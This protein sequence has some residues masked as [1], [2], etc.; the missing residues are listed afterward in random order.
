M[1]IAPAMLLQKR[2]NW[3]KKPS[4]LP[5]AENPQHVLKSNHKKSVM[6]ALFFTGIVWCLASVAYSQPDTDYCWQQILQS[7]R[8]EGNDVFFINATTGWAISGSSIIHTSDGGKNWQSQTSGTDFLLTAV[9][10]IDQQTGWAVGEHGVILKTIN[11]GRDWLNLPYGST[12]DLYDVF[13]TDQQTGWAVGWGGK[14]FKTTDGGDNW[15][16]RTVL[17]VELFAV[18]FTDSQTGWTVSW[19][20][21]IFKTTDGGENWQAL[22]VDANMLTAVYFTDGQTGWTAG[23]DGKLFKTSNGGMSWEPQL[24]G[25]SHMLT[26]VHF[27]D[28]L[29]GWIT[30]AGGTILHT[31]DGGLH[32]QP[33]DLGILINLRAICFVDS[34]RGWLVGDGII[35]ST[36]NGGASWNWT[37]GFMAAHF[38]DTQ[39]GWLVCADGALLHTTDGGA[40]WHQQPSG[41]SS[42]LTAVYFTDSLRGWVGGWGGAMLHT[43]DG[44]ASWLPQK[45]VEAKGAI[46]GIQF[47]DQQTGWAIYSETGFYSWGAL[48]HTTDGGENWQLESPGSA[49]MFEYYFADIRFI[50]EKTGW[51]AGSKWVGEPEPGFIAI[52]FHTTDGGQSWQLQ[53][54]DSAAAYFPG[55]YFTD[56]M[57][58]W[59]VVN[60]Y[61]S[62]GH[63]NGNTILHTSN[64]GENWAP[65]WFDSTAILQDVF[66]IDRFTGWA[67][68]N[69]GLILHTTD[70]GKQ[71]QKQSSGAAY[72]LNSVQFVDNQTGWALAGGRVLLKYSGVAA[73]VAAFSWSAQADTVQFSSASS[74]GAAFLWDFGDGKTSNEEN[75]LH[76]Y[77]AAGTYLVR[78][79]VTNTC[80]SIAAAEQTVTA[81]SA[82]SAPGFLEVFELRPNPA[83]DHF[84]VFLEGRPENFLALDFLGVT[85]QRI[86]TEILDFRS[87]STQKTFPCKDVPRGVYLIRVFDANRCDYRKIII[88]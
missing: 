23:S 81:A 29:T 26:A 68:G 45:T 55:I 27:T 24:S 7:S 64:G 28:S 77:S 85:G 65:Q 75:P 32:W 51:A 5:P 49:A 83:G 2:E 41:I 13:F 63:F 88:R 48:L 66:F 16:T 1:T 18:Y 10:F 42:D 9:Y 40:G 70:G 56:S 44:G 69:D 52:I 31:T 82:V 22:T 6:K 43:T 47:T 15:L 34:Q 62:N 59:A 86:S 76:R 60:H 33:Q 71:W 17:P 72:D 14:I 67:V 20:G 4:F 58:G 80:G 38:S 3:R 73:P 25:T 11:G 37:P 53:V 74:N 46:R 12:T 30:G 50:D 8:I 79:T 19:G 87:G 54:S 57:K 78:L 21:R 36:T 61:D 84:T 39:N 35:S